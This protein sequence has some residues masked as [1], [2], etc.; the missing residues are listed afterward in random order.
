MLSSNLLNG[1]AVTH[2]WVVLH[3]SLWAGHMGRAA[4]LKIQT[5]QF[6]VIFTFTFFTVV[7]FFFRHLFNAFSTSFNPTVDLVYYGAYFGANLV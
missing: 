5:E 1:S 3:V 7:Y 2:F 6:F 4:Y